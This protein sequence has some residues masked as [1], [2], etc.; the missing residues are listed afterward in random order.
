MRESPICITARSGP[1]CAGLDSS[2]ASVEADAVRLR[3]LLQ[4]DHNACE[5]LE[6][7]RAGACSPRATSAAAPGVRRIRVG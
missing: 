1:S 3:Q 6:A 5:A 7:R 4:F 2:L